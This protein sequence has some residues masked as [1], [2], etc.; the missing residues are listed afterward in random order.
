MLAL[1]VCVHGAQPPSLRLLFSP[2][3]CFLYAL[4]I[5][6]IWP[7]LSLLVRIRS[8][9]HFTCNSNPPPRSGKKGVAQYKC[10]LWVV[11]APL[12]RGR[13]SGCSAGFFFLSSL[14]HFSTQPSKLTAAL[15]FVCHDESPASALRVHHSVCSYTKKLKATSRTKTEHANAVD[16]T[17]IIDL[18]REKRLQKQTCH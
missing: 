14:Q 7:K 16:V 9:I 15:M 13:R 10:S 3:A 4:L 11:S 12:R 17:V 6:V 18:K 1:R 8:L 2:S 5:T